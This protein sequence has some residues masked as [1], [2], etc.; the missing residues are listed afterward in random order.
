MPRELI[1]KTEFGKRCKPPISRQA[2]DKAIAAG[3]VAPF[4][5]NLMRASDVETFNQGRA[6]QMPAET[7][8]DHDLKRENL[9]AKTK[10]ENALAEKARLESDALA[11]ELLYKEDVEALQSEMV[12]AARAKLLALPT[13]IAAE[14]AAK[15]GADEAEVQA[16]AKKLVDE[17]LREL[18]EYD[19]EEYRRYARVKGRKIAEGKSA[20]QRVGGPASRGAGEV[21]RSRVKEPGKGKVGKSKKAPSPQPSPPGEGEGKRSP[22]GRGRKA[23]GIRG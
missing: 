13:R 9:I 12:M 23:V 1:S 4:K 19:P 7:K 10:R 15:C 18:S 14:I 5:G 8:T 6:I 22:A 17:A 2:V 16:L 3:K 20:G 11:G 21:K